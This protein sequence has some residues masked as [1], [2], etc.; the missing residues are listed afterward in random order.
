MID[1]ILDRRWLASLLFA[2]LLIILWQCVGAFEL[3]PP[4][5]LTPWGILDALVATTVDGTLPLA[6]VQSVLLQLSGF[7]V[8]AIA[9]VVLG[10]TAGV[11]R[12]AEDFIDPVVSLAYP[13][14]KIALFPVVVIWFGYTD[15]SRAL[16]IATSCFF[17]VFVN[18]YAGTRGI[19]PRLLWVARNADAG[20]ARIFLQVILRAA[21]PAVSNGIRISL[22]LSF[23]LT[24]ATETIGSSAGGLGSMIED[25]FND[26][27]YGPL[28]AGIVAFAVLGLAADRIWVGLSAMWTRGQSVEAIGRV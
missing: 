24:Y 19:E 4:Y 16:V 13:L 27:Q 22:G 25:G 7:A 1:A 12:W 18:A 8:G 3:L 15:F 9:G 11:S 28:W 5:V 2:L 10:L 17:P 23:I 21:M 20:K 26:L 14:P 6:S